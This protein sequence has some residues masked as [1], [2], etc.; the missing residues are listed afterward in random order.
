[1]KI[2]EYLKRYK[3]DPVVQ[4]IS[5]IIKP[6]KSFNVRLKGLKGSI[7]AVLASAVFQLNHQNFLFILHDKEEAAYFHNDF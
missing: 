6:N 7:D 5:E 4:T 1:M 3:E 2:R